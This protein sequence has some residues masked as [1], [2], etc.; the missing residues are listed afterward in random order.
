MLVLVQA[1]EPFNESSF[2]AAAGP[3]A[4]YLW[5]VAPNASDITQHGWTWDAAAAGG[6]PLQNG[7]LC[8]SSDHNFSFASCT[9][10][11]QRFVLEPKASGKLAKGNLHPVG[12]ALG[13]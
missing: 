1:E 6:A 2:V 5:A 9:H 11:P 12:D 4:E 3:A 7:G 8:L 10:S 13:C